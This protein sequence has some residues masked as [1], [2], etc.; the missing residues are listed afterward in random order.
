MFDTMSSG[1]EDNVKVA[2]VAEEEAI[3]YRNLK[4]KLVAF[5]AGSGSTDPRDSDL[6]SY[7]EIAIPIILAQFRD[8]GILEQLDLIVQVGKKHGDPIHD[9]SMAAASRRDNLAVPPDNGGDQDMAEDT[10]VEHMTRE[11]PGNKPFSARPLQDGYRAPTTDTDT[12]MGNNEDQWALPIPGCELRGERA[13]QGGSQVVGASDK[14]DVSQTGPTPTTQRKRVKIV[15]PTLLEYPTKDGKVQ[16]SVP[17]ISFDEHEMKTRSEDILKFLKD[18]VTHLWDLVP[19]ETFGSCLERTEIDAVNLYANRRLFPTLLNSHGTLRVQDN[20]RRNVLS[21]ITGQY[22]Q[23]LGDDDVEQEGINKA[24]RERRKKAMRDAVRKEMQANPQQQANILQD[25]AEHFRSLKIDC[26]VVADFY[27]ENSEMIRRGKAHTEIKFTED[28]P[29]IAQGLGLLVQLKK[30]QSV[31]D[32]AGLDVERWKHTELLALTATSERVRQELSL[33]FIICKRM[34]D[35][36]ANSEL[37]LAALL[38]HLQHMISKYGSINLSEYTID[39]LL[40]HLRHQ[41]AGIRSEQIAAITQQLEIPDRWVGGVGSMRIPT[42]A[43]GRQGGKEQES[44]DKSIAVKY[45][46]MK[47]SYEQNIAALK[48]GHTKDVTLLKECHKRDVAALAEKY[49][50]SKKKAETAA[51]AELDDQRRM[52]S[53]VNTGNVQRISQLTGE[54]ERTQMELRAIQA[55]TDTNLR[56]QV[57]ALNNELDALKA[58]AAGHM[59]EARVARAELQAYRVQLRSLLGNTN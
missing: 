25:L 52:F 40:P 57:E 43:T 14:R 53:T 11:V 48:E 35:R 41:T 58:E 24:E 19:Q 39:D 6:W 10:D 49:K 7:L 8:A 46:L 29:I 28:A 21:A 18:K 33:L 2:S 12:H 22:T 5:I 31:K 50:T 44:V 45:N 13:G 55:D 16:L 59:E 47:E 38:I 36:L 1:P 37:D 34:G 26:G 30:E 32:R 9:K 54:L 3:F 23:L 51:R 17:R 56:G 27:E 4:T 42:T 15:H 20:W